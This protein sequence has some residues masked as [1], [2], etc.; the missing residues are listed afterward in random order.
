MSSFSFVS[1]IT[2]TKI[3]LTLEEKSYLFFNLVLI[4]V[5]VA[6]V[7]LGL[8]SVVEIL[9]SAICA[10]YSESLQTSCTRYNEALIDLS[11]GC[12]L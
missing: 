4:V 8:P 12:C 7:P 9:V 5:V 1:S 2:V 3:N 11:V 6:A 10:K